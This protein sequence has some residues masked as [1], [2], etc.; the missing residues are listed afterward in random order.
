M[1]IMDIMNKYIKIAYESRWLDP[2]FDKVVLCEACRESNAMDV[3]HILWR[4]WKHNIDNRMYDPN[5]LIFVC[6]DCHSKKT[7]WD[8][9]KRW[10]IVE[11]KLKGE[12]YFL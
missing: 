4:W 12:E 5:N 2:E 11:A 1:K 3:D 6:R 10:K 9:Q 8:K 7:Y